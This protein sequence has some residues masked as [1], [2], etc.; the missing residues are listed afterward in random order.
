[1]MF[2]IVSKMNELPFS[3]SFILSVF[4]QIWN[5][6]IDFSLN[7]PHTRIIKIADTGMFPIKILH[8]NTFR[9]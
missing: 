6:V 8:I 7:F 9:S 3:C 5:F 1:M 4:V 2:R